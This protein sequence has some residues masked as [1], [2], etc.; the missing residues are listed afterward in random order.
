MNKTKMKSR[1]YFFFSLI[2]TLLLSACGVRNHHGFVGED[3]RFANYT[4]LGTDGDGSTGLAYYADETN[5]NEIAVAIGTCTAQD[6]VVSTYN[7]KPVTSVFPSG[8]LNCDTIRTV[9]LPDTVT[10]FGTDAFAG[11]SLVSITIPNGLTVISS[12]AFRNCRSL[13]EVD[14]DKDDGQV[15]TINDYAFANDYNLSTFAFHTISNLKTI[16]KEA[17]LY[18][19]GLRSVIFPKGFT[20]LSSYAFQDCKGLTTIYFPDSIASI[21][22]YAFRGVGESAK[23]YFSESRATTV[24][25]LDLTDPNPGTSIPFEDAHNFSFGN[26]YVPIVFEVGDLMIDGPF[27]FSHPDTGSYALNLYHSDA[28][29]NWQDQQTPEYLETLADDEVILWYYEDDGRTELDIPSTI[30]WGDEKKVVGIKAEVFSEKTA[31]EKVTFHEN[32][33]FIDAAAF[34]DC[35]NLK[36]IDFSEAVDLKHIQSRAFYNTMLH[37]D[38]H[39]ADHMYSVHIPFNVEN[40]AVDAFRACTGLFKVYFDGATNEYE[41]IFICDGTT[42]TFKL[43]YVP[44][45]ITSVTY[46]NPKTNSYS[47]TGGDTITI[48]TAPAKASVVKVKFTTNSTTTQRFKGHKENGTLVTE[49]VLS[50]KAEAIGSITV[51]GEAKTL[52]TDYTVTHIENN[53]K[54]KVTFTSAPADGSAILVSYRTLSKLTKIDAC[55]FYG[56]STKRGESS[57]NN[58]QLRQYFDPFQ[59][60]YFPASLETIGSYAFA[61]GDFIGG[62]IFQSPSLTIYNHAFYDQRCLSSIVFP[63]SMTSLVLNNKSFA[64]GLGVNDYVAGNTYK[65]LFSV[66]LPSNTTVSANEIF[67]GRFL[68]TI[69]CINN[70]PAGYNSKGSWNKLGSDVINTFGDFSGNATKTEMDWAPVYVVG[71]ADDIISLPSKENPIFD[72]VKE[73]EN[74]VSY[75]TLSNY[76]FHGGRITDQDGDSAIVPGKTLNDDKPA[77]INS[78][79]NSEYAVRLSNG[80]FRLEVPS[81]VLINGSWLNVKKIGKSALSLQINASNIHP[82]NDASEKKRTDTGTNSG[83]YIYW[84][85]SR[86]Y[87]TM[88]EITLPD[89]IVSIEDAA[90]AVIPF[91][92]LKSYDPATASKPS[93]DLKSYIYDSNKTISALGEFP[94]SLQKIGKKAFVFS[95]ITHA[96]LPSSLVEFGGITASPAPDPATSYYFFP[97][98][99]CFNLEMLSMPVASSVFE[100]YDDGVLLYKSTGVMIEGAEGKDTI[101]IPWGTTST[102]VGAIRGGRNITTV[103]FPY[104]LT[105]VPQSFLD[106][107]GSSRDDQG[108]SCRSALTTVTFDK[109]PNDASTS[110]KETYNTSHCASIG[111]S[112]FYGCDMLKYLDLPENLTSI[113]VYAF[114]YCSSLD[115]ITIDRGTTNTAPFTDNG[116]ITLHS[117]LDFTKLPNLYDLGTNCF[118][119]CTSLTQVTT[120]SALTTLTDNDFLN[121]AGITTLTLDSA[122]TSIGASCFS[123][124]KALSSAT[125]NGTGITFKNTSFKDCDALTKVRI[126]ANSILNNGVFS[127]CDGLDDDLANGGGVIVG[128]GV[129]FTGQNGNSAFI[130][131]PQNTRIFLEDTSS[132]YTAGQNSSPSRYPSGWNCYYYSGSG[133]T[134]PFYCFS[135]TA[136]ESTSPNWGYWHWENDIVGSK[137]VIWPQ[138]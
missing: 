48:T 49:F 40:I 129:K 114:R 58:L 3:A 76:H 47:W 100:T 42:T 96:I 56:C 106:T 12:G 102:F 128:T 13:V 109:A 41:E 64:A 26:Y 94:S 81:Q 14:F 25:T 130:S 44:S 51:G 104:T 9:T 69:Y 137:P 5:P 74:G 138:S 124:C 62:T 45:S 131:C 120:S 28:N 65:K 55:A 119:S 59:N 19:L 24:E 79:Y 92:T 111:R 72:F 108:R 35:T 67:W 15:T 27:H 11:S 132:Q 54:T 125:F 1:L 115:E 39:D 70:L 83:S 112:A 61:E 29:G 103:H 34:R 32:L 43:P 95:G 38:T 88:W 87:W 60:I 101:T 136:P 123:G 93:S 86:N 66:I 22:E 57:Y 89:S 71:S 98:M 52:G 33:R 118:E 6:V 99:G 31:I 21:G 63:T 134:L 126:P 85:D 53:T 77:N 127:S 84:K 16:G 113:G 107:I 10:T 18:C 68:L 82:K 91:P 75:A 17:F 97:F 135:A 73:T 23:I 4:F 50:S 133:R 117:H 46:S 36:T 105:S 20:T 30:V 37:K 80:H 116:D 90:M 2:G 122:T 110:D 7:S 8:F 78:N 121:C